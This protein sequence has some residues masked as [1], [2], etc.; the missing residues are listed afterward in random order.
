MG[1]WDLILVR[2]ETVFVSVQDRCTVCD[3][4]NIGS[5]IVLDALD[6]TPRS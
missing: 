3:K 1:V 4:R 5:Q 2:L 6:G